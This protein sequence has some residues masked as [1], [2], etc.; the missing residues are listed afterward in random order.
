MSFLLGFIGTILGIIVA[1]LIVIAIIVNRLDKAFGT[2]NMKMLINAIKN[3]KQLAQEEYAREK[4]VNGMTKLIEPEI[5]RDF[6]EFNKNL[7]FNKV[8]SNLRKIFNSI[9][10]KSIN[11]IKNDEDLILIFST[12][13][14][15]IQDLKTRNVEI[16]YNDVVFHRHAIKKYM[17]TKGM[18]TITTSTTLEYYYND[19]EK[20]D[21]YNNIKKQTRYTCEFVYI[22]DENKLGEY[23]KVFSIP[24]PNGGAPLKKFDNGDIEC[25]YCSSN[26]K[27]INL[28]LWKMSSYKED[29]K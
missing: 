3:H 24:C 4:N 8:E 14:E 15:Q 27:P 5:I 7:L 13:K 6:P 2:A 29:Y 11:E 21:T 10:N 17:K 12:L 9:E 16:K 20:D 1:I 18:A 26:V 22:Y 28:K 19:S 25:E 23:K